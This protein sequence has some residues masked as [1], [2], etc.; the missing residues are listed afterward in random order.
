MNLAHSGDSTL[1]YLASIG[2]T[3]QLLLVIV[4]GRVRLIT[5]AFGDYALI[6]WTSILDDIRRGI[7]EPCENWYDLK[8]MMRKRSVEEFYKEMEMTMLGAQIREREEVTIVRFMQGLNKD[9]QDEVD[10]H[11]YGSLGELVHQVVKVEILQKRWSALRRYTASTSGW[12][13]KYKEKEKVRSN[14]SPKK[15]SEPFLGPKKLFVTPSTPRTSSIKCFKCLG[16]GHI[17]L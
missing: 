15:G 16:K 14:K 1:E 13:G 4:T 2:G 17:A 9:I 7:I 6:W 8:C 11:V 3:L 10:L 12:K 5:L